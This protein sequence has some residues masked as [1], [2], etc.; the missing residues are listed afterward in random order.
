MPIGGK[1]LRGHDLPEPTDRSIGLLFM[2]GSALFGVGSFP[3]ANRWDPRFDGAAYA[4]GAVFFTAAASLQLLQSLGPP[5]PGSPPPVLGL[6]RLRLVEQVACGVQLVGTLWFNV[7]TVDA[8]ASNLTAREAERRIWYPD[9]FGSVC[10]LVASYLAIAA[11]SGSWRLRLRGPHDQEGRIAELNWWGSIAFGISAVG[12]IVLP[13]GK[14]LDYAVATAGT[15]V[16][17]V[18]FFLGAR[19]MLPRV[20]GKSKLPA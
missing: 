2:V 15:F 20:R 8:L 17:A 19:L 5:E 3:I 14:D 12:G 6:P 16:G 9:A 18:C 1:R 7:M 4:V 13:S 11:V 10:F